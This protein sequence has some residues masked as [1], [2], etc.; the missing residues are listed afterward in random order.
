MSLSLTPTRLAALTLAAAMAAL[1]L[2]AAL[3]ARADGF[4]APGAPGAAGQFSPVTPT[5]IHSSDDGEVRDLADRLAKT[6]GT[7]LTRNPGDTGH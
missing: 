2:V 4:G 6:D 7:L 3:P 1:P 5:G